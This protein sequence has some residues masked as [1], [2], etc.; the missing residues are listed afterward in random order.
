MPYAKWLEYVLLN[1]SAAAAIALD[2]CILVILK[3]REF[4]STIIALKWASAVGCT[5][6]AFPMLGFVGGWFIIQQYHLPVIVYTTGA[7]LLLVLLY[8]VVEESIQTD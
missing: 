1:F 3:F 2:A 5:H 7:L 8:L 4:K 6:I